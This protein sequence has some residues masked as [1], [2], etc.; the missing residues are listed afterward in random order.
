MITTWDDLKYWDSGEW[1]II[2]EK[3]D[4]LD[5]KK[6]AYN[7]SREN[8]FAALDATPFETVRVAI[9]GQDPY[10]LAEH[11]TGIAFSVPKNIIKLPPTLVNI[12]RVYKSDLGYTQPTRGDLTK[13][14]ERGVLLLNAIPTCNR[15]KPLS[16][17]WDEP[18]SWSWFTK[19]IIENLSEKG[20]VFAFL[21]AVARRYVSLVDADCNGIIETSHPS[22]RGTITK[23]GNRSSWI[24]FLES[25]LFSTINAKLIEEGMETVDWRL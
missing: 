12:F 3:L 20:I 6:I 7:P 9:V 16:H 10:P 8:I 1:Q 5:K 11:A 15:F 14:C 24:P 2:Q 18:D 17:D 23:P 25:R 4:D 13:W 22:P 19:E 21:G